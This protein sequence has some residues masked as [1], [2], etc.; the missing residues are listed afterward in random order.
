MKY[1]AE[2]EINKP[3]STVV[4]LFDNEDNL[5]KWMQGL[6]SIEHIEGN[7]G[8]VGCKTKMIFKQGK[9]EI[10]MIETLLKHDLPDDFCAS[11]EA[12]GVYNLAKISFSSIDAQS[13]RYYTE[14]EF[15]LK[16]FMKVFGFIMPGAFKKQTMKYL[17]MFKEFVEEQD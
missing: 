7:P 10:V 14:Q 4:A 17:K 11:Y 9:R 1:T 5:F 12:K 15:L 3:L 16:G 8:E 6:Q 2:I 13:T